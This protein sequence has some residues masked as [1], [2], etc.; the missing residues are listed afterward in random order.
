MRHWFWLGLCLIG[1]NALAGGGVGTDCQ[2]LVLVLDKSL[3]AA[4]V[5][6][7]WASGNTRSGELAVLELRGCQGELLDRLVLASSL[8]RLDPVALRGTALPAYLV[9]ADLTAEAGSY[10]GPLTIP[11]EIVGGHLQTAVAQRAN[12]RTEP[13]RL[14]LTGKAAWRRVKGRN[15]VDDLLSV[16]S[17]LQPP[18][19]VTE[20]RRFHPTAQ[21]WRLTERSAPGL[22]ESDA[23]F[24]ALHQFPAA[25]PGRATTAPPP[26]ARPAATA[27]VR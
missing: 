25:P 2:R 27:A 26:P 9:S 6:R 19:F 7:E 15:N 8:A 10:N 22:W 14:A 4:T 1:F 21:G 23:E 11:V 16:S 5:E 13:I 24:P 18:G 12:G 3:S 20:Y 17:R